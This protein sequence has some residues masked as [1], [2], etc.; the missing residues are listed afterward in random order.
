MREKGAIPLAP[1]P[2]WVPHHILATQPLR[3]KMTQKL[4][5]FHLFQGPTILKQW[6]LEVSRGHRPPFQRFS[7]QDKGKPSPILHP[8]L[9]ELCM[10]YI[11]YYIPL[12]TISPQKSNGDN[13]KAQLSHWNSSHQSTN[14][15]LKEEFEILHLEIYGDTQKTI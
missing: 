10:R 2:R 5:N 8:G 15:F 7:P 1:N 11:G 9:Q 12:C 4:K 14:L 13:F 3:A 6:P